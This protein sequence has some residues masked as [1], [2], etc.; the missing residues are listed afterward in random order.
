VFGASRPNPAVFRF[1]HDAASQ[2]GICGDPGD[3]SIS[4]EDVSAHDNPDDSPA[5]ARAAPGSLR[6]DFRL[7]S[8]DCD[9]F[10]F[11]FDGKGVRWWR[12]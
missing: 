6:K 3:A 8:G 2:G 1:R 4:V 12:R 11:F 5:E 10:H 9:A 7:D